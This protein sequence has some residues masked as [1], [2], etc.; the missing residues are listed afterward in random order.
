[1]NTIEILQQKINEAKDLDFGTI[2]STSIELFKK[3]W[4]Q[5]FVVL[6]LNMLLM[7]PFYI[8]MYVPLIAM[9]FMDSESF[10]ND[11]EL[12]FAIMLPFYGLIIV[13]IFFFCNY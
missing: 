13:F 7:L 11:G 2:F 12:N 4:L 9:G 3:V 10:A 1:M 6:L 5:G 8:L